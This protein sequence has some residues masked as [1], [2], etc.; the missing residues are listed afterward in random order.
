M[1]ENGT[2]EQCL[3]MLRS[4]Y[5]N[6]MTS[7]ILK[8]HAFYLNI[9]PTNFHSYSTITLIIQ[10]YLGFRPKNPS[11]IRTELRCSN[12]WAGN[13]KEPSGVETH[14]A[15]RFLIKEK[16]KATAKPDSPPKKRESERERK[17]K[18]SEGRITYL[19]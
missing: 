10:W 2:I 5:L 8:K 17:E 11:R 13:R 4:K 19:I 14:S 12:I 18:T 9:Y 3:F 15:D 6:L 1:E 16:R 7:S